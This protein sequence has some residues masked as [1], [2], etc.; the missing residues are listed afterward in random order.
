MK[1]IIYV[2]EDD[3]GICEVYEGAFEDS[4]DARFF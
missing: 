2:V 1:P 3:E 4:Y